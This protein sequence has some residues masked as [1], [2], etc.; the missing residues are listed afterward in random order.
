VNGKTIWDEAASRGWL[1]SLPRSMASG[2]FANR[3]AEKAQ[4]FASGAGAR[5]PDV[6]GALGSLKESLPSIPGMH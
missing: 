2:D 5:V 3:A 6:S 1:R 4:E